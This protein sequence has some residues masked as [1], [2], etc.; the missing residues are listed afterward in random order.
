MMNYDDLATTL[1]H[2]P[3]IRLLQSQ[4]APLIL[5]FLHQQFKDNHRL[6]ITHGELSEKLEDYLEALAETYPGKYRDTAVHYLRTWCDDDHQFLRRYYETEHDEPVYELT[7]DTERAIAWVEELQKSDFVGTE[8]RFIRIFDLL[9]EIV[10]YGS[11]DA[12]TRLARL[13]AEKARLQAEIDEIKA[14]GR[15][16]PYSKTQIKERFFEANDLARRLLAD[17]REVEENFRTIARQ[18]QIKQLEAG[19]RKGQILQHVLEADAALKESD[20]G[21]SF[22]AFWAFLVS[23][24]KQAELQELLS[25]VFQLPDIERASPTEQQRLRTI[26]RDLVDAGAKVIASNRRLSEQL[27]RLLDEQ[28]MAEARRVIELTAEIKQ[29]AAALADN[30]LE[31]PDFFT[32]ETLP[33]VDMPMERPLWSPSETP[34]FADTEPAA[35]LVDLTAVNL[36]TLYNQFYI[37]ESRLRRQIAILLD[38]QPQVTLGQL[39][40][41]YPLEKGLPELVAYFAIATKERAHH[42]SAEQ[43]EIL[44]LDGDQTSRI[45]L[46]LITF[47]R[48]ENNE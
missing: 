40:A 46:P 45:R 26:K 5:S 7:P 11:E 38:K 23:P 8:S 4:H 21:R 43:Q 9:S 31:E 18:V 36:E 27:R 44:W 1:R 16:E 48:E 10:T 41:A 6:T 32:I 42:I 37:D 17:F 34:R 14:T 20:Q 13:E 29:A 15:I 35:G 33:T 39:V 2:S 25:A 24:G 30:P 47:K 19:A 28:S 3:A 12:A 22:Y